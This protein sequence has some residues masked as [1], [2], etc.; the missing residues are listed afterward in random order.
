MVIN[1]T[2][3]R[4]CRNFRINN[5]EIDGNDYSFE[6]I[7]KFQNV[8]I[9]SDDLSTINNNKI[10]NISL[11]Y[12]LSKELEEEL[13][14]NSNVDLDF[15]VIKDE[16]IRIDFGFDKENVK[17]VSKINI[18]ANENTKSSFVIVL[19]SDE[20]TKY[21]SNLLINVIA[22]NSSKVSITFVNFINNI[23]YNF[24][25]V[26]NELYENADVNYKI[27]DF[28]GK[29]SI[30]NYYS[31]LLENNANNDINTIYIGSK[32]EVYDLNYITHLRGE[33]TKVNIE[34]EGAL[35]S[36]AKKNFKGTIDFKKGCKKAVGSEEENCILLSNEAKSIAL[37]MLL[38]S[39]EDVEGNHA[40]SAGKIDEKELFYIM[41]RGFSIKEAEK[42]LV[43]AR[44]NKLIEKIEDEN[45]KELILEEIDKRL[46]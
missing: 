30:T 19:K 20:D 27:V 45:L 1:N 4:T 38:C 17:L 6:K 5:I 24:L 41:S 9:E 15:E 22:N 10:N 31:N 25:S 12:G 40:T 33:K 44:F 8:K 32:D 21:F 29:Y 26:N 42:L 7:N 18:R 37:P 2:P 39:E 28:G 14:N 3:V 34:V 11:E 16:K 23:S 43:R 36:N 13:N 35:N 46:D